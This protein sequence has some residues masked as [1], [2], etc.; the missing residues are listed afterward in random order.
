MSASD[1]LSKS[2]FPYTFSYKNTEN[3]GLID[4]AVNA[5]HKGSHV[6]YMVFGHAG[7][8]EDINV[9]KEH[10]R[11]GVATGMWNHAVSLGGSTD[12]ATGVRIPNIEHSENRTAQGE[13]WAKSTGKAHYFPPKE[14]H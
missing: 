13:E 14:I 11:K 12:K 8:V 4:H 5:Y 9:D 6:G 7:V 3:E 2:Q 1:H 10:Q